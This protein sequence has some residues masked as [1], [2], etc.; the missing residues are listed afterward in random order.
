MS[1][2]LCAVHKSALFEKVQCRNYV[3]AEHFVAEQ[4]HAEGYP[5]GLRLP[6]YEYLPVMESRV[7]KRSQLGN[8]EDASASRRK[9]HIVVWT[10]VVTGLAR[11]TRV[12]YGIAC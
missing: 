5:Q 6:S 1:P 11:R 10:A 2:P 3:A 4:Y 8:G 12:S 9:S 7:Y